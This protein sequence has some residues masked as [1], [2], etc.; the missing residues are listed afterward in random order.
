M[1]RVVRKAL[2]EGSRHNEESI[3]GIMLEEHATTWGRRVTQ[4]LKVLDLEEEGV[5]TKGQAVGFSAY[6]EPEDGE[7]S[8]SSSIATQDEADI[9]DREVGS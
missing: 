9:R 8:E 3:K 5:A 6:G 2:F 4:A 1:R 7:G